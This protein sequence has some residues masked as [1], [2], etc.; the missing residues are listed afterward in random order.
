MECY[1]TTVQKSVKELLGTN[2]AKLESASLRLEKFLQYGKNMQG[3]LNS[4]CSSIN[5]NGKK[6]IPKK[7]LPPGS[8]H[9]AMRSAAR[10]MINQSGSILNLGILIH[11]HYGCPYIPGSALKGVT[12]H[13][14][15]ENKLLEPEKTEQLF[16]RQESGGLVAFHEAFPADTAWSMIVDVLTSHHG[17]ETRN[18]LPIL[19]PALEKGSLFSFALSP[20]RGCSEEQLNICA[21]FLKEALK[22]NG[23]GAKTSAG[24]G[25]FREV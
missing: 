17:S 20:L 1:I 15:A 21:R 16:G 18:P 3:E 25:W 4:I 9:F 22:Q 7:D 8:I 11:R 6:N 23:I 24:Y 12:R 13:Y 19:F 14:V 2:F 5:Q 10:M